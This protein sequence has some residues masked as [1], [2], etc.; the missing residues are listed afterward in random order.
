VKTTQNAKVSDIRKLKSMVNTLAV[1]SKEAD[2]MAQ[3]LQEVMIQ[4]KAMTPTTVI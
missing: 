3:S 1:T 2:L 4:E